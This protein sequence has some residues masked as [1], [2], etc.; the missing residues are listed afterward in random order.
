M[1]KIVIC[2]AVK[3][4][5]SKHA[6]NIPP[7]AMALQMSNVYMWRV[8]SFF[9]IICFIGLVCYKHTFHVGRAASSF[10][11]SRGASL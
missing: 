1:Q 5:L 3:W 8:T 11:V 4:V 2:S 6:L 10:K 7:Q 9:S